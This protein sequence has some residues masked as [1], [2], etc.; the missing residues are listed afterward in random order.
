MVQGGFWSRLSGRVGA[1]A[2]VEIKG[3]GEFIFV[4]QDARAGNG[5]G[6]CVWAK[7][8]W[9]KA[10][11]A[12]AASIAQTGRRVGAGPNPT[13]DGG[14][15]AGAV[16]AL[17]LASVIPALCRNDEIACQNAFANVTPYVRGSLTLPEISPVFPGVVASTS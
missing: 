9:Q 13:D 8:A 17:P 4:T 11:G 6:V 7:A 16:D 15:A 3:A 2:E 10:A 14:F 12:S 1:R 5:P